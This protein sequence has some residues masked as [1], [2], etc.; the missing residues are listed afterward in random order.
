MENLEFNY[1]IS[2]VSS[3]IRFYYEG[4]VSNLLRNLYPKVNKP[5]VYTSGNI[6]QQKY[7]Y[8]YWVKVPVQIPKS[9]LAHGLHGF[10]VLFQL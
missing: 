6:F 7:G 10:I 3:R 4:T 1:M 2:K 9:L 8:R 5:V